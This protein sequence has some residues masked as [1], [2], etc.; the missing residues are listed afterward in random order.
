[1][2]P[3]TGECLDNWSGTLVCPDGTGSVYAIGVY[4]SG[5]SHCIANDDSNVPDEFVSIVSDTAR[6]AIIEIIQTNSGKME[7]Q[8]D[9][10]CSDGKYRHDHVA[11]VQ[12][13][14]EIFQV[15]NSNV[16]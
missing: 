14:L 15:P 10:A 5:P 4:H 7:A 13:S 6:Q 9:E 12:L 16:H 8:D 2:C 1:M 3:P 11:H